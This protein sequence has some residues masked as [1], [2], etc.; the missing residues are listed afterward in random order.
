MSLHEWFVKYQSDNK[1]FDKAVKLWFLESQT[2]GM[3]N[4][5]RR[6]KK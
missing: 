4:V 6:E 3:K 5:I 2:G 1:V